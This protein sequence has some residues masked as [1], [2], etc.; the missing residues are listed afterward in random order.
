M[1]FT[2]CPH[3]EVKGQ[4]FRLKDTGGGGVGGEG[5]PEIID[6]T[7]K[8]SS[9]KQTQ[10]RKTWVVDKVSGSSKELEN[11]THD[12]CYH[13]NMDA[14]YITSHHYFY[15][16]YFSLMSKHAV[17]ITHNASWPR[18]LGQPISCLLLLTCP[19]VCTILVCIIV[20]FSILAQG[21][22]RVFLHTF[23]LDFWLRG[24]NSALQFVV[25]RPL[26]ERR[27]MW[28]R[29]RKSLSLWEMW[30]WS[31]ETQNTERSIFTTHLNKE[32]SGAGGFT[33]CSSEALQTDDK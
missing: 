28:E 20:T 19:G 8:S 21:R 1:D 13:S 7:F 25:Y 29:D 33:C 15:S 6:L 10:K 24:Q 11:G 3:R 16:I 31:A 32:F 30:F 23:P 4:G 12:R 14:Y 18:L 5:P 27:S 2:P 26:K 17:F 9:V 22:T